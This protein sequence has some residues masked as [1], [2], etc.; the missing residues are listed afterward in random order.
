MKTAEQL[1]LF[2]E[3]KPGVLSEVCA[4]LAA[5]KINIRAVTVADHVDHAVIRMVVDKPARAIHVLGERGALVIV[6]PVLEVSLRDRPGAL[7]TLARRLARKRVNIDYLY[8]SAVGGR[9][10]A[11]LF[12]RVSDLRKARALR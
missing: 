11:T 7:G 9:G 10:R 1:S 3:N 12:L 6:S 2:L 4:D 8:G 5:H